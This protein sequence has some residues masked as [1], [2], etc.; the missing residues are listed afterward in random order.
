MGRGVAGRDAWLP[1]CQRRRRRKQTWRQE[2]G[3]SD[4]DFFFPP[5]KEGPSGT[6]VSTF[7]LSC[8]CGFLFAP[9]CV[10]YFF[11]FK[12]ERHHFSRFGQNGTQDMSEKLHMMERATEHL[13]LPCHLGNTRT[14]GMRVDVFTSVQVSWKVGQWSQTGNKQSRAELTPNLM[15][16]GKCSISLHFQ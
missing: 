6:Y 9:G 12:G 7:I 14:Q 2:L 1:R 3:R 16:H 8:N 15:L 10:I 13:R 11:F 4:C 5:S